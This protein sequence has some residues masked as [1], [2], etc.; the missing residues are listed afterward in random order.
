MS[1]RCAPAS[2]LALVREPQTLSNGTYPMHPELRSG[3]SWRDVNLW[4]GDRPSVVSASGRSFASS[5]REIF[6]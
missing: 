5:S 6:S 4:I 1:P 3:Y 2:V